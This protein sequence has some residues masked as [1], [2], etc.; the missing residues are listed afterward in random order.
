MLAALVETFALSDDEAARLTDLA[1]TTAGQASD[2][3][4]FTSRINEH[5]DMPDKLRMVEQMWRV[6]YAEGCLSD[7]E[8]HVLWR[9]SDLLHVPQAA[10]V[11]ARAAG[12]RL[13]DGLATATHCLPRRKAMGVEPTRRGREANASHRF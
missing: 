2:L 7:H 13:T 8:R 11:H 5:L 4:G 6:A 9:I 12:R 10:Y 3:F 1:E